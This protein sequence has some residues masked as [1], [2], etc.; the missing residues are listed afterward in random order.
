[1]FP[2]DVR[3]SRENRVRQ[4]SFLVTDLIGALETVGASV[5]FFTFTEADR[6]R[7]IDVVEFADKALAERAA[8]KIGIETAANMA[9]FD[10]IGEFVRISAHVCAPN[11]GVVVMDGS[12]CL[13]IH[14]LLIAAA[15]PSISHQ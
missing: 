9:R 8:I 7:A 1:M 12:L 3:A 10:L 15:R 11:G 6:F 13:I 14:A 4:V 2:D 5:A